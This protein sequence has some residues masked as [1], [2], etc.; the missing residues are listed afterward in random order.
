MVDK[1]KFIAYAKTLDK[2][3]LYSTEMELILELIKEIEDLKRE[4]TK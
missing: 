1:G 3:E 4:V 2:K